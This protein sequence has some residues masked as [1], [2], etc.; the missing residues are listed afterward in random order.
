[1]LF[2]NLNVTIVVHSVLLLFA[3]SC[4]RGPNRRGF[5]QFRRA[6]TVRYTYVQC[7]VMDF[8]E[9]PNW[10]KQEA[11]EMNQIELI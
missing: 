3:D 1:M 11:I 8:L 4:H 7:Y 10:N 5:K 6:L 2:S 9:L